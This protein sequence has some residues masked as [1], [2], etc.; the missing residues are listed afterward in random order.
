MSLFPL[1]S[2]KESA[3][4]SSANV[5]VRKMLIE[6]VGALESSRMTI[7]QVKLSLK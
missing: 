3:G 7:L 4:K 6:E 1:V 5:L 2:L